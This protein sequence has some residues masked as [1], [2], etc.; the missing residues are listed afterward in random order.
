MPHCSNCEGTKIDGPWG[1]GGRI[2][3]VPATRL[4]YRATNDNGGRKCVMT[5]T[6]GYARN[7]QGS[8]ASWPGYGLRLQALELR[9][10]LTKKIEARNNA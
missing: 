4:S 6:P 3:T 9:A 8:V 2:K 1:K 7:F 5:Q 10:E